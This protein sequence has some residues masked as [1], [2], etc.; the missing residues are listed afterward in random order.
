MTK[1]APQKASTKAISSLEK[2][3]ISQ[4]NKAQYCF[5]LRDSKSHTKVRKQSPRHISIDH[6]EKYQAYFALSEYK[7][8]QGHMLSYEHHTLAL[9]V[10]AYA[11]F[12][13]YTTDTDLGELY[14]H[15]SKGY[16]VQYTE[17]NSSDVST[18]VSEYFELNIQLNARFKVTY[19]ARL[20]RGQCPLE[21]RELWCVVEDQVSYIEPQLKLQLAQEK[22]SRIYWLSTPP[23][24]GSLQYIP[25]SSRYWMGE[26]Y[27]KRLYR[28]PCYN[29]LPGFEYEAKLSPTHLAIDESLLPYSVIER[30]QTE[31]V[32][33]YLPKGKGRVG[34]REGRASL[35]KK[36]KKVLIDGILKRSE[37]KSQGLSMWQMTQD[38]QGRSM[39]VDTI[40]LAGSTSQSTELSIDQKQAQDL[41]QMRRVKRQLYLLHPQSHRV[42]ALCL[43][44]CRAPKRLPFHQIELEYNGKLCL[45][46]DLLNRSDWLSFAPQ[47]KAA[48]DLAESFP[49]AALRCLERAQLFLAQN[50]TQASDTE[51]EKLRVIS[52]QLQVQLSQESSGRTTNSETDLYVNQETIALIEAEVIAEMKQVLDSLV[53]LQSCYT[54]VQTKRAWLKGTH[55]SS[56][57]ESNRKSKPKK[58]KDKK[59]DKTKLDT[60]KIDTKKSKQ[61]SKKKTKKVN[62]KAQ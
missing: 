42:Y 57:K 53:Q 29:E 32:R 1:R 5:D 44:D 33:W 26:Y 23:Q 3:Y 36:G 22:H 28:L 50:Q 11:V 7:S 37:E 2:L 59:K 46:L 45:D 21:Q 51:I 54:S 27:Y 4:F 41:L 60:K 31:S 25:L 8:R 30:Y 38:L 52:E 18:Y 61:S 16:S 15:H 47:F 34:F 9:P 48:Q 35:V 40:K 12:E 10:G 20:M 19:R 49:K 14:L 55:S 24:L 62:K 13:Q 39:S 17:L 6:F 58:S 56:P 43:D